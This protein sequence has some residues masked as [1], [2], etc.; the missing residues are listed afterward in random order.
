MPTKGGQAAVNAEDRFIGSAIPFRL[1][2]EAAVG[3]VSCQSTVAVPLPQR[4]ASRKYIIFVNYICHYGIYD[5]LDC[6]QH[7]TTWKP[8]RKATVAQV[9]A[10]GYDAYLTKEDPCV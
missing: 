1:C 8:R 10:A 2:S 5:R 7:G 9:P 4:A 3:R 6:K